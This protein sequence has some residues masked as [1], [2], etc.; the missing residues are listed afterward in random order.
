[1]N[2]MK[3]FL[4]INET[5]YIIDKETDKEYSAQFFKMQV[6]TASGPWDGNDFVVI[7]DIKI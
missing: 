3:V 2:A 6:G 1:M 5:L 4:H 7:K